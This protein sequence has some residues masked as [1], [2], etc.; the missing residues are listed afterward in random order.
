MKNEVKVKS[1]AFN[2]SDPFQN[3]LFKH[4]LK[5]KNFSFYVKTLISNDLGIHI[6]GRDESE[7]TEF[8]N[9]IEFIEE[10]QSD[11]DIFKNFI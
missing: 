9:D 8:K 2:L 7:N 10:K 11:E 5:Y 4:S 6:E 3:K 1:I